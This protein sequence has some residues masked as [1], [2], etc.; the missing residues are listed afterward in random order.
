MRDNPSR[1]HRKTRKRC[2][3]LRL[4]KGNRIS[5]LRQNVRF[6]RLTRLRDAAAALRARALLTLF[7]L[8][9]GKAAEAS[10]EF[11]AAKR[12]LQAI[13]GVSNPSTI[14]SIAATLAFQHQADTAFA[15]LARV[16]PD[17]RRLFSEDARLD[18]LRKDHRFAHWLSRS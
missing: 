4:R 12:A 14:I 13:G 3:S 6:N 7:Y 16:D 17:S 8:Q 18:A 1:N 2:S 5:A 10:R 11:L 15:W 9:D